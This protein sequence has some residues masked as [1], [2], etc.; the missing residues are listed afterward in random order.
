MACYTWMTSLPTTTTLTLVYR[1]FA[2]W[3]TVPLQRLRLRSTRV[4][5]WTRGRALPT[6]CCYAGCD[7]QPPPVCTLQRLRWQDYRA[8]HCAQQHTWIVQLADTVDSGFFTPQR[9]PPPPLL[10]ARITVRTP[11]HSHGLPQQHALRLRCTYRL[12]LPLILCSLRRLYHSCGITSSAV[13]RCLGT[14]LSQNCSGAP[15]RLH[16]AC[17]GC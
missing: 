5:V 10:A 14:D 6:H 13:R 9:G 15:S 3:R 8:A 12:V 4:P 11:V 16:T 2:C 1:R 17:P 7:S